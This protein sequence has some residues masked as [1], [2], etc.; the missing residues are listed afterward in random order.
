MS[1]QTGSYREILSNDKDLVLFL[2]ALKKFDGTFCKF[3]SSGEDFNLRF[4]VRG[5]RSGLVSCK[6]ST[7]DIM[8]S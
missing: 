1:D 4:E 2:R 5:N 6:I 3:M 8:R 7:E